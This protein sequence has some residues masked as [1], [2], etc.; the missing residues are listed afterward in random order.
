VVDWD[1]C[2]VEIEGDLV[3][4][5]AAFE[6]EDP[7]GT[8]RGSRSPYWLTVAGGRVVGIEEQYLP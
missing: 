5:A 6:E 2:C 7:S 4:F 1:H 8:Y 3:L